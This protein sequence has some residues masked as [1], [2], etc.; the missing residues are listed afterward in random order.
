VALP[1]GGF[2]NIPA[3][4]AVPRLGG[5]PWARVEGQPQE[6]IDWQDPAVPRDGG[7]RRGF[8]W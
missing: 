2:T 1:S 4:I 8:N 5:S 7:G 3:P 6:S